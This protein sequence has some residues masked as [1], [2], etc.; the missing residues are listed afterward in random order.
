MIDHLYDI[1]AIRVQHILLYRRIDTVY[2]FRVVL[3]LA[4]GHGLDARH[5]TNDNRCKYTIL[6]L[7]DRR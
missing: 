3:E 5:T 7:L 4:V 1:G 6:K 2:K